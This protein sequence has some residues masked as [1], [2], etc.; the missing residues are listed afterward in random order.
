MV[1]E[2]QEEIEG[3]RKQ[4]MALSYDIGSY[5]VPVHRKKLEPTSTTGS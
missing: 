2:S 1:K 3:C 4:D 5:R